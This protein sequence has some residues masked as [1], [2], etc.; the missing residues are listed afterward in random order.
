MVKKYKEKTPEEIAKEAGKLKAN[1]V[2]GDATIQT[3]DV[4][5][6][7]KPANIQAPTAVAAPTVQTTQGTA[8]TAAQQDPIKVATMEA[9]TAG[10]LAATQAAQGTVTQGAATAQGPEFTDANKVA[11]AQRDTAQETAAQAQ[12]QDF[13]MDTKSMVDQVTGQQVTVATTP[14]AEQQQREAITGVS[15]TDGEAAQIINTAGYEAAQRRT[16]TGTE[17]KGAAASM[18]AEVGNIPADISAAIVEDPATVTAQV[19]TQPV[20][21]QAAIA[22]LPTEA[23]VSSQME[24][25]LAGMDEGV[26][27]TWAR[28]AVAAVQSQMAARGLNA[29]T[30]GRDALFNAIIQ[31]AM[32]IAQS[33]AQALQQRAAQN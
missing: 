20:E 13:T 31:S 8:T 22:A 18:V 10:D 7:D 28:P 11:T 14:A 32:P 9:A 29:S 17:A 12:V 27:P 26:T 2:S 3:T 30:V 23:L 33:N 25:L 16:V 5:Q 1:V 6:M 21:V 15:A 4:Q 19:D 24:T